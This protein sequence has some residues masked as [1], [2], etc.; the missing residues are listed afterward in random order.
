MEDCCYCQHRNSCME[1]SRCYPC[2]SYKKG[3]RKKGMQQRE[4]ALYKRRLLSLIPAK[5]QGIPNREV[6][7][8]FFRSS[9]IE[10]VEKEKDWQ[11]TGEQAAELIRM[12]IYPD[13]RSEEERMQY[14]DFLMNGLDR[15][16]S[17]NEE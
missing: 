10:Q 2:A 8:K 4:F 6:K 12:A 11:F 16:M 3:R 17:E 13:L 7:I 5:L 15:V 14:E 1:R 9:L